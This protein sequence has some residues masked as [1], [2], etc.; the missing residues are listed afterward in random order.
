MS[1]NPIL[2]FDFDGVIVDG[3]E[4]YWTSARKAL[5]KLLN[6][7]STSISLPDSTPPAFRELRPWVQHGWEMILL[8]AELT[9]SNSQL[10]SKRSTMCSNYYKQKCNEAL[11]Y[12][13]W[14]PIQLQNT[15]DN[16]R[17]E[18]I[19]IDKTIWLKSYRAFPGIINRLNNFKSE[20]IDIVVLTTKSVEFT[21]HLLNYLNIKTTLLFGHESGAK[22]KVLMELSKKYIIKGFVEDRRATLETVKNNSKLSSIPCYLASWGYL[23][24]NDTKNLPLDIHLLE[25]T[26]FATPLANWS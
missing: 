20:G 11:D 2:V 15:L 24:P 6:E 3:I 10:I 5:I 22:T 21:A 9:R 19:S 17:K 18:S 7:N 25:K 16:I 4:E 13:E 14:S 1:K 23:K 26:T 12:W 8:V